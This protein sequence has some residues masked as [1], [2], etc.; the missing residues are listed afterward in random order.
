M[1]KCSVSNSHDFTMTLL[2]CSASL[3]I[4]KFLKSY[5]PI[6]ILPSIK[7]KTKLVLVLSGVEKK[8][9]NMTQLYPESSKFRRKIQRS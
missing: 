5:F 7:S 4:F 2:I 1:K 8:H 9:E 6:R 3:E